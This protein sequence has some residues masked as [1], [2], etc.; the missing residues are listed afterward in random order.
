MGPMTSIKLPATLASLE[1]FT[2]FISEWLRRHGES[3]KRMMAIELALEEA[4][5]NVCRYAYHEQTGDV[6]VRCR[7]VNDNRLLI[8]V[9][10]S[11]VPFDVCSLPPPDVKSC[12]A[13]RKIG[14]LGVH[15][16]RKMADTIEYQRKDGCNILS[17]TFQATSERAPGATSLRSNA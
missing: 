8:E 3:P 1:K 11:G 9:I 4:L 10:D 14:G 13:E 17:L 5:V 12:V 2:T 7:V 16:I 15:F 6:E